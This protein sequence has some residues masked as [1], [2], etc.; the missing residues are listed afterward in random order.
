MRGVGSS[1]ARARARSREPGVSIPIDLAREQIAE[2]KSI[3]TAYQMINLEAD[4]RRFA[5]LLDEAAGAENILVRLI[6]GIG[7]KLCGAKLA[8]QR[9][10]CDLDREEQGE[11]PQQHVPRPKPEYSVRPEA[12][13]AVTPMTR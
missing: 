1:I 10:N 9:G 2:P 12:R 3:G 6:D 11:R 8:E 4:R 5:N 13:K 7:M